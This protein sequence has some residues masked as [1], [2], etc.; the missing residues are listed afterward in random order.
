MQ[1][2]THTVKDPDGIHARPAGL[3]LQRL[4]SCQSSVTMAARG[5]SACLKGGGIFALLGLGVRGGETVTI[6]IEGE[7][8]TEDAQAVRAALEELI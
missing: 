2:F 5:G 1:T 4:S 3:L 7:S 6:T 8:E